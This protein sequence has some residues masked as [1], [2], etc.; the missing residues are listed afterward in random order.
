MIGKKLLPEDIENSEEIQ[1]WLSQF[2]NKDILTVKSLLCRLHFI[3]K[4]EFSNWLL[5]KLAQYSKLEEESKLIAIYSVRKFDGIENESLWLENGKLHPRPAQTQGSEDFVSSIISNATRQHKKRFLDHPS[6]DDIRYNKV[7]NII[8]VD[9]S[10]GSGKRVG[11]FIKSLARNKT[12]LS[13]WSRGYI[14]I[15]VLS[16]ARTIQSEKNILKHAPGS[17]CVTRKIKLSSKLVFESDVVYDVNKLHTRWGKTSDAIL[18]LCSSTKGIARNRRK[19]Y[20]NVMGNI[21]FYHSVPNNIPGLLYVPSEKWN[22]LFPGRVLPNWLINLLDRRSGSKKNN[23]QEKDLMFDFLNLIKSGLRT[24]ASLSRRLDCDV[25]ITQEFID[26]AIKIG[27]ISDRMRL[28][29]S[30]KNHL[31]KKNNLKKELDYTLYIPY[32]WTADQGTI[33]PSEFALLH[34]VNSDRFH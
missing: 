1:L 21:V 6:I 26:D 19:G 16:Y 12:F 34:R 3:S 13:W 28:T 10:I 2:L 29:K 24:R 17:N 11:K 22:P 15:R 32:T 23:L 5:E 33:Q 7:R 8:L 27:F 30:G 14:T 25:K 4:D 18:S 9:D 31:C 20:G